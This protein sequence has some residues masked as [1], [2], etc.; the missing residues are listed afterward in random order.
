MQDIE[1]LITRRRRQVL[2]NSC[3]YYRYGKSIVS[4]KQFDKW[5][6]EL[7]D[8]QGKYPELARRGEFATEFEGFDGTTGFDLPLYGQWV[9]RKA[10]SLIEYAEKHGL[11][12]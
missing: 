5:A 6:Y 1:E 4:D 11:V 12:I 7:A 9:D 3:I 2:V 10:Q 8:L